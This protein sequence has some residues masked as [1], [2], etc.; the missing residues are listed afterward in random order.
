MKKRKK[1]LFSVE[2]KERPSHYS[3]R[4]RGGKVESPF[5]PKRG[6][7]PSPGERK[8]GEEDPAPLFTVF[9]REKKRETRGASYCSWQGKKKW[10]W[11]S[12]TPGALARKRK[13]VQVFLFLVT[14]ER[15]KGGKTDHVFS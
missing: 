5:P 7:P 6:E 3:S 9:K 8:E 11:F 1:V 15:R 12:P 2:K 14:E 4:E 10:G 13:K